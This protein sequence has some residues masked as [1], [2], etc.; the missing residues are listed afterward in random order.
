MKKNILRRKILIFELNGFGIIILA[1]WAN[2]IFDLPHRLFNA[3]LT[4]VNFIESSMETIL[5]LILAAFIIPFSMHF[6]NKIK[7]LEGFLPVC[8][9]CK[10]IR[11]GNDWIPIERYLEGHTDV[12]LTHG[13]CP[14]CMEEYYQKGKFD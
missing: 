6:L 13:L 2:E 5:V 8:A 14:H 9:R 3:P 7:Y 1:L 10:R 12:D 11:V 4:P